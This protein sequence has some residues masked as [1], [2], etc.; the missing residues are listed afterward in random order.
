MGLPPS[1]DAPLSTAEALTVLHELGHTVHSLLSQTAL[2]HVSGTRG[3]VDFVEF[4][5]HLFEHF[6]F[7]P[8][9]MCAHA[10][11]PKTQK[12]IPEQLLHDIQHRR[13]LVG[14]IEM[15][16]TLLHSLVD[17]SLYVKPLGSPTIAGMQ[18]AVDAS[19][20]TLSKEHDLTG[21]F[22]NHRLVDFLSP[23]VP[24][25]FDHLVHYSG[26]YFCYLLDK[27]L[28][29]HVWDRTFKGD[30]YNKQAGDRL[31]NFLE[32][33]SSEPRLGAILELTGESAPIG[34]TVPLE[35]LLL[36]CRA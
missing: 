22:G 14:H 17:H 26:T 12:P 16:N 24:S 10:I 20:A 2:Q 5:S 34:S 11:D 29:C 25:K 35:A 3:T 4:P 13:K 8:E 36:D 31:R 7:E 1:L 28:S 32:L 9:F 30:P 18:S 19:Y 27:A 21:A 23:P 15:S 33:G 6:L